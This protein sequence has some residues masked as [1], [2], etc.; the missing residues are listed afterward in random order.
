MLTA[1][2][3]L[4][5]LQ[6]AQ[7]AR[8]VLDR[9]ASVARH[10][11]RQ[12]R[13][14]QAEH[15]TRAI[16]RLRELLQGFL[17][18]GLLPCGADTLEHIH[19]IEDLARI[20]PL[21]RES[22]Q[23]LLPALQRC[24]A[25]DP[26]AKL[27][28]SGGSTGEPTRFYLPADLDTTVLPFRRQ[29]MAMM[30]LRHGMPK[31]CLW[32]SEAELG[33]KEYKPRLPHPLLENHMYLGYAPS[34]QDYHRFLQDVRRCR[35]C[36]VYGYTRLLEECSRLA[37]DRGWSIPPGTVKS[38]W[39]TAEM[40]LPEQRTLIASAFGRGPSDFYGSRECSLIS[41]QCSHG[42]R[43]IS[44]RYIMEVLDDGMQ[45]ALPLGKQG[46]LALTDLFNPC[47]PF[48]RYVIGDLG[49][50]EWR[51]CPCGHNGYVLSE[52]LG[53]VHEMIPLPD[54]RKVIS[55]YA[56]ML[57]KL[58]PEIRLSQLLHSAP[59]ELELHYVGEELSPRRQ[60]E[61]QTALLKLL[62]GLQLSFKR[63]EQLE[64]TH[65]GKLR[66]YRNVMEH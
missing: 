23:Q 33:L 17:N 5:L 62:Q 21:T 61:L 52:L 28:N 16:R 14:I 13:I 55:L 27:F 39:T 32:G 59:D 57:I 29:L 24:W 22:L 12:R 9:R 26:Q 20:A 18:L 6:S 42:T 46:M 47:T 11:V 35:G 25:G 64:L 3:P 4:W 58:V 66:L 45:S 8:N 49:A 37:L 7:Y 40:L 19:S 10:W 34:E 1:H 31:Y 53:R 30:G 48:I 2:A 41:A 63:V 54:G 43:H 15:D 56:H 38:L 36:A 65:T 50:V 44:P 60:S 51:E